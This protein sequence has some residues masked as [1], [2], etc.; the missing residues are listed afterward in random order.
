MA[1]TTP[2]TFTAGTVLTAANLNILSDD[3]SYL[4]GI[5]D[6]VAL[7]GVQL[8]RAASQSISNDTDTNFSWDTESLD[9]GGWWSS[10]TAATVPAG[11][12]P[13]GFTTIAVLVLASAKF[14]SNGTGKRRIKILKNGST[15][16]SWTI[17]AVSGDVTDVVLSDVFT[18]AAGDTIA[19]AAYQNSGSS[20]N[21]T[22]GAI[23]ILRYAPAS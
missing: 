10:G 20:L 4:K 11:A 1:W 19:L 9:Y 15:T 13:S 7:S 8:R 18:V 21:A 22:E 14:A 6:G 12:I 2:P 3:L 5:T 23:T 17:G 16:G